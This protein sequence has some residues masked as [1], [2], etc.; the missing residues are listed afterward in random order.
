MVSQHSL[1]HKRVL[2]AVGVLNA[3]LN[4]TGRF[5]LFFC[6]VHGMRDEDDIETAGTFPTRRGMP[7]KRN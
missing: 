1:Y 2:N 5:F 6:C 4:Y 3:S 7:C